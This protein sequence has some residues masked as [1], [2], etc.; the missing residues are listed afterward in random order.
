MPF[1]LRTHPDGTMSLCSIY[2]PGI[3]PTDRAAHQV[4]HEAVADHNQSIRTGHG[5]TISLPFHYDHAAPPPTS[6]PKRARLPRLF[7]WIAGFLLWIAILSVAVPSIFSSTA[8]DA[9]RP[10]SCETLPL[11]RTDPAS[12]GGR[13]FK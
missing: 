2:G 6:H 8:N 12:I 1:D 10:V 11:H 9:G 5:P 4:L 3:A 13:K 7:A